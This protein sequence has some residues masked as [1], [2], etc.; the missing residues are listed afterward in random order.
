MRSVYWKYFGFKTLV[1]THS[2]SLCRTRHTKEIISKRIM[3]N[4]RKRHS[5]RKEDK[6]N[7]LR[8]EIKRLKKRID[9]QEKDKL[10]CSGK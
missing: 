5:V 2:S 7:V 6:E 1:R 10:R 3:S 9:R 4:K 8:K